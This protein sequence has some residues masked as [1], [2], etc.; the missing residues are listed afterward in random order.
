[1]SCTVFV[2]QLM[3]ISRNSS[4]FKNEANGK[5]IGSNW[6]PFCTISQG[7][8]Y[9]PTH[10]R[11]IITV[12]GQSYVMRLPKYWPPTPLSARRVCIYPPPLLRGEDTLAGWRGGWGSI[13]WKTQDTALYSIYIESS[14]LHIH[15]DNSP[16][17]HDWGDRKRERW[18]SGEEQVMLLCVG[19]VDDGMTDLKP[20]KY[21][22]R[23]SAHFFLNPLSWDFQPPNM[24]STSNLYLCPK[25]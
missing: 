19:L 20:L 14:L 8:K 7:I 3:R 2:L 17:Q 13:F 16:W 25:D 18:R 15:V 24:I 4:S 12:R 6:T 1:M 21:F 23:W 11:E 10:R 5:H 9:V 22:R